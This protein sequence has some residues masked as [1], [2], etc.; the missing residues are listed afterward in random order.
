[1]QVGSIYILGGGGLFSLFN[2]V[3]RYSLQVLTGPRPVVGFSLLSGPQGQP[4]CV[5]DAEGG[6]AGAGTRR[7]AAVRNPGSSPAAPEKQ[8]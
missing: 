1:M 4:V 7:E 2:I 8:K 5:R 3:T 6:D